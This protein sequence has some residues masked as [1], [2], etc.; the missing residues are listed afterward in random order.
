MATS[1]VVSANSVRP[2]AAIGIDGSCY[3]RSDAKL[4]VDE[5]GW[6]SDHPIFDEVFKR[7]R[8]KMVCE[9]GTWKGASVLHMHALAKTYGLQTHFICIDTWLGSNDLLWL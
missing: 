9:I 6:H 3:E 5:Q 4:T 7:H 8:P 1:A 2:L